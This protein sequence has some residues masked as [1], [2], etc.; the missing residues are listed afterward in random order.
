MGQL[1]EYAQPAPD[2]QR[3][4]EFAGLL[5]GT[6][7]ARRTSR[8]RRRGKRTKNATVGAST[9]FESPNATVTRRSR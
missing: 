2:V 5:T 4:Y 1:A 9:I 3:L 6:E 7:L 8:A